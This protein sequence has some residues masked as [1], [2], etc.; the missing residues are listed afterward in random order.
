MVSSY[1]LHWGAKRGSEL[2]NE[3]SKR[4]R[5][6]GSMNGFHPIV[7]SHGSKQLVIDSKGEFL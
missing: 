3:M 4:G 1:G 2:R 5:K 6:H 7:S